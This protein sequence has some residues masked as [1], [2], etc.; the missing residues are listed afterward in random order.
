MMNKAFENLNFFKAL[1]KTPLFVVY[2][3][4]FACHSAPEVDDK[5]VFR[6]NRYDNIS[7]LDPAFAR[8]QSN[9]WV[10][11]L[12][13][14]GLVGF[15][16]ELNIVPEIAK[17]WDIAAD[18]L[19]YTF[20]LNTHIFFHPNKYFG[21]KKTRAVKAQDVV[22]SFERLRDPNLNS[23]GGFVLNNVEGFKALN[24]SVFQI[25]L[26][27]PF[28]PFLGLLCMKYCSV[29]PQEV[30][31]HAG[32]SGFT[33][34]G[35]G[36]FQFQFWEPNVKL[37]LKKN[38][39]FYHFDSKGERLPYLEYVNVLFLPEKHSEFL[40]LIQGK[41]DFMASLNPSYKDELIDEMGDL[42]KKYTH[43]LQ[44]LKSPYLNTEYLCFYLGGDKSVSEDLRRAINAAIDKEKMIKY[45]RNNIGFAANGGFIPKGL[46][47]YRD[48]LG[49]G[50]NPQKAHQIIQEIKE[51]KAL[52]KLS[53]V[54]TQEYVDMCEFVQSELAKVGL[55]IEINNVDPAT[56][57]E[58]KAN[59]K[60]N[61]FRANWGADYPDAENYLSLFYS[62]N[63]AP[64]GPNY[65]HFRN[66]KFDELYLQSLQSTEIEERIK[67]YWQMD[68]IVMREMPVIPIFYDQVSV[69][70]QKNIKGFKNSPINMLDLTRV[71]K[72]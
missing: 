20:Y 8:N 53:L 43:Q 32:E 37:V 31:Q 36:P 27:K 68:E 59:G 63:F 69:F 47:G 16:E 34:S 14:T 56:L 1:K 72:E 21:K 66:R 57:R 55:A 4:I 28:P 15:D 45:L 52:P 44:M 26:K 64:Q 58:G 62:E 24:D 42:Q 60:F 71:Y 38:P 41:I 49:S 18:K 40:Q 50:Y 30:F 23:S 25:K 19:T 2:I 70:L 11:N 61:F 35:T 3:F 5:K 48:S 67:L 46:P 39:L 29:V 51:K 6:L 10:A 7:S 33:P 13:Y 65:S 9:N 17:S 22:Y 12:M 54:T